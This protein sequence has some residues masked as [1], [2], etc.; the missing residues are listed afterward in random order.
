MQRSLLMVLV[1]VLAAHSA[2]AE[3]QPTDAAKKPHPIKAT[4]FL[5][6]IQ[7]E[8]DVVAISAA[9]KKLASVTSVDVST[10]AE[11]AIVG[12][13][14]H[15]VSFHQV[16]QAIED[17][18]NKIGRNFD[19][20]LV[21]NVPEYSQ[22]DNAAKIDAIF[23]AKPMTERVNIVVLDKAKGQF[24]VHFQPL[25]LDPAATGPQ[26]FNLG[27]L[28]HPI[29]DAPPKGLGLKFSVLREELEK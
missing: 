2:Q 22:G 5:S 3:D 1:V 20:R 28:G 6:D 7:G 19:P 10:E 23:E 8:E 18:G 21:I 27:Q 12:F 15:V 13:D 29:H 16:A 24:E 17:A 14:T 11:F 26:G 9:V 25:T 4:F